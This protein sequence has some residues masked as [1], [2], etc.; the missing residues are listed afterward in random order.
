[1]CVYA[2]H[3]IC[4]S[5][6]RHFGYFQVL[7]IVNSAA[8]NMAMQVSFPVSVVSFSRYVT[9]MELQDHTVFLILIF[10]ENPC[11]FSIVAAPIYI[12]TNN[13]QGFSSLCILANA[14]YF[15]SFLILAILTGVRCHFT[16]VFICISLMVSDV[17]HLLHAFWP[18]VCYLWENVYSYMLPIFKLDFFGHLGGLVS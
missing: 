1:M 5:I 13:A 15:L 17:E 8:M 10:G 4:S 12:P 7:A 14:C 9:R 6:D 16:M 3:F 11:C 2:P 18:S